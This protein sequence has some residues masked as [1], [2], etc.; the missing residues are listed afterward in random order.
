[1]MLN[2]ITQPSDSKSVVPG[3]LMLRFCGIYLCLLQSN[4]ILLAPET[5][6]YY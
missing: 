5:E 2:E 1:M 3:F 4:E 6:L